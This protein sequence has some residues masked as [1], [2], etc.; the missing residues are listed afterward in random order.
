MNGRWVYFIGVR[1]VYDLEI[2]SIRRKK[3][4]MGKGRKEKKEW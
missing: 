2:N 3:Y 4:E 1:L